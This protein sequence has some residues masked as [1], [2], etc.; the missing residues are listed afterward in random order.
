MRMRE[1]RERRIGK[2]EEKERE[3]RGVGIVRQARGKREAKRK[4][5]KG[6]GEKIRRSDERK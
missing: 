3:G 4:G 1:D 6:V 5:E 2:D